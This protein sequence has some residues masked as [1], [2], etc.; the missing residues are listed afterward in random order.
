MKF[1]GMD[2]GEKYWNIK[3]G[4]MQGIRMCGNGIKNGLEWEI[5]RGGTICWEDENEESE[6]RKFQFACFCTNYV[7]KNYTKRVHLF[8]PRP[9]NV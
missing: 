3:G 5:L 2:M 7:L 6:S 4:T 9:L 8:K 1:N